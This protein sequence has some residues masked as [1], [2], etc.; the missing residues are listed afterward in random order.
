ML[1][2][3]AG[4][5]PQAAIARAARSGR[6]DVL[7]ELAS[8]PWPAHV[9][10]LMGGADC[11]SAAVGFEIGADFLA[12]DELFECELIVNVLSEPAQIPAQTAALRFLERAIA[13]KP[14]LIEA[15]LATSRGRIGIVEQICRFAEDDRFEAR[16]A[17]A[18]AFIAI[19]RYASTAQLE[20]ISP[21]YSVPLL[22]QIAPA[23]AG[24]ECRDLIDAL[25]AVVRAARIDGSYD[26]DEI[27]EAHGGNEVIA[28]FADTD[29]GAVAADAAALIA[30]IGRSCE[31][32]EG[33]VFIDF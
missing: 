16:E 4:A 1:R 5:V 28:D 18:K 32:E 2:E 10:A 26:I 15:V 14:Q 17:A 23:V 25:A 6:A 7:A 12:P 9:R 33:Q 24:E 13:H 29:D 27:F 22:L 3:C 20:E 30:E 11:V 21:N 19:A 31:S 8:G